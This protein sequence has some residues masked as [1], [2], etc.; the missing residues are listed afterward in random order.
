M[1]STDAE[2]YNPG[3]SAAVVLQ[4]REH[5]A[6]SYRGPMRD[7]PPS[8]GVLDAFGVGGR[9]RS[10]PGG[11]GGSWSVGHLVLKRDA[12]SC[13]GW[14]GEA[15]AAVQP[16]GVRIAEPVPTRSGSWRHEGWVATRW[17]EGV[18]PNASAAATW[19]DILDAG[20]AFHRAVA[21]LPR[22]P[23]LDERQD[24]W[25]AADRAAWGEGP[26]Q[27]HPEFTSVGRR[28]RNALEP[29]GSSQLVHGDLSGNVL[30]APGLPPAVIDVSPYWRPPEY[31]EGVVL[32]DALC[33]H[34]APPSLLKEAGVSV[35]AV[36]RGL[37]FR[38]LTTSERVA[39]G[40]LKAVDVDEEAAR[41]EEAASAIGL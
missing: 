20:R 30:F 41:Y 25:A 23:C 5:P 15:L 29:L 24:P 13:H 34:D 26:V 22:P 7:A 18:E 38:M 32:A 28:L 37:L 1:H 16:E 2:R 4:G 31:A 19:A 36:A 39:S 35:A 10:L 3:A 17:V 6:A 11:Q 8:T 40:G 14:L 9:P 33:W 27:L 12:G 21:D